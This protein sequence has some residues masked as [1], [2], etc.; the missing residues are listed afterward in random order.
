MEPECLELPDSLVVDQLA[1]S[2]ADSSLT[3]LFDRAVPA[4]AVRGYC[5]VLFPPK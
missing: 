4:S 3:E 1:G 5:S 2:Q